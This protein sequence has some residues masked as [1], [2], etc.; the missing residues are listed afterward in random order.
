MGTKSCNVLGNMCVLTLQIVTYLLLHFLGFI[1][2]ATNKLWKGKNKRT[3]GDI[4][5]ADN[6]QLLLDYPGE[7]ICSCSSMFSLPCAVIERCQKIYKASE[8]SQLQ[9]LR[10]PQCTLPSAATG[11]MSAFSSAVRHLPHVLIYIHEYFLCNN[12]Q[13]QQP[14]LCWRF[15]YSV[16]ILLC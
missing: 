3:I 10:R 14:R 9:N 15:S 5:T 12:P 4:W 16:C 6:M 8:R 2:S 13:Q 7:R 11:R 1:F